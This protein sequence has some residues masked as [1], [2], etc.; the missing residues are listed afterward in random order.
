[1]VTAFHTTDLVE[2]YSY[3]TAEAAARLGVSRRT[4]LRMAAE[5]SV[6]SYRVGRC[7][8]YPII[9]LDV[10]LESASDRRHHWP[11]QGAG[12]QTACPVCS[13]KSS[14]AATAAYAM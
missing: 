5:G 12:S 9:E 2:P 4:V 8:R 6:R 14:E 10:Q 13:P 11:R 7:V 3:S 1:M